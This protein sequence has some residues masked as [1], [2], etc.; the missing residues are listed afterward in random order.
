MTEWYRHETSLRIQKKSVSLPTLKHA[1]MKRLLALLAVAMLTGGAA[2]AQTGSTKKK[3]KTSIGE[4]V[5]KFWKKV[6]NEVTYTA[7]GLFSKDDNDLSL[8]DGNY[9]MQVYDTNLYKGADGAAMR[10]LCKEQ[11]AAKYPN[12]IVTSCVIPQ[13]QWLSN[14][15]KDDDNVVG[16][17]QTMYC[18]VLAKDGADG[19]IN[20]KY[21]FLRTKDVGKAYKNDGGNWGR[22]LRTDVLSNEVYGELTKKKKSKR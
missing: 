9:Y 15:V 3:E 16:Y 22:C 14:S 2:S 17:V 19:Y 6:K 21:V 8:V 5:S 18:Y 13:Q 7:D 20:A 10:R 1:A 4:S 11:F 12:A